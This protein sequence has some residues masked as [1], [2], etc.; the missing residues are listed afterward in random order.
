MR[1]PVVTAAV[2]LFV[3]PATVRRPGGATACAPL[4]EGGWSRHQSALH[5][6]RQ[7]AKAPEAT[8]TSV[9]ADRGEHRRE[10]ERGG[11]PQ[12]DDQSR[13]EQRHLLGHQSI[14]G[15]KGEGNSTC[16]QGEFNR[17]SEDGP[18]AVGDYAWARRV[19]PS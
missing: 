18:M 8:G 19:R 17:V 2:L 7:E 11:E 13:T 14:R 15:Q 5:R 12:S 10:R 16:S 9:L 1:E 6:P 4:R 3:Q